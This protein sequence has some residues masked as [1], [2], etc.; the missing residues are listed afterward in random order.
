MAK[1]YLSFSHISESVC[2]QS[3]ATDYTL[4]VLLFSSATTNKTLFTAWRPKKNLKH[5]AV[6]FINTNFAVLRLLVVYDLCA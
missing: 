5:C 4:L 2:G 6:L 1:I 3:G